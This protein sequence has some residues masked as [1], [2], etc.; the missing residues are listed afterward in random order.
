MTRAR[1]H[2]REAELLQHRSDIAF[3][4]V[5]AKNGLPLLGDSV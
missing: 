2:M 4:I 3:V 1:A 5:D